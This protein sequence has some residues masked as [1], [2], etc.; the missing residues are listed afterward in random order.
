MILF[1]NGQIFDGDSFVTWMLVNDDGRIE[2]TGN[3]REPKVRNTYDLKNKFVL[4]GF[5]DGH[6]HVY[7][8]GLQKRRLHLNGISSIDSL[9]TALLEFT[10][11]HKNDK[12]IV[13]HGWDQDLFVENRY[14][15]RADLD[16]VEG[17]LP[18]ILFRAC[19]HIAV[20]NTPAINELGLTVSTKIEG[21][22][23]DSINGELTGV[24]RENALQLVKSELEIDSFENRVETLKQGLAEVTKV[25]ITSVQTND[26]NAWFLYKFLVDSN[27]LNIR[28]FLTIPYKEIDMNQ[29]PKPK[30]ETGL[31]RAER[32][33]LFADGSLGASTAAL[34]E[35]YY[36][37][38]GSGS[39][40]RGILIDDFE[41]LRSKVDHIRKSGWDIE[42]HA[43][44]DLACQNVLKIYQEVYGSSSRP[45]V[46]HVQVIN[47][48]I[49]ELFLQTNAIANIQPAFLPTDRV[50][51]EQRLGD[52][53]KL[54]YA[55]RTLIES[56]IHVSGGSDAPIELPDPLSGIYAA[57]FRKS[58]EQDSSWNSEE[59]ISIENAVKLF[60][61]SPSFNVHEE[62]RI[63]K[64]KTGYFADFNIFSKN[65]LADPSLIPTT[66]I[67][68][69]YVNGKVIY[70]PSKSN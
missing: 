9:K 8:I 56:G 23:L 18:V 61:H 24:I 52:R 36:D 17:T 37:G 70:H 21:G 4:P 35:P 63:G 53:A 39:D 2:S 49:I 44:G 41:T 66:Q 15:T 69:V 16:E 55:W 45:I 43:I 5:H 62:N 50:W 20:I 30:E 59:A 42:T 65:F 29:S 58:Y 34:I 12:W 68:S 10:K 6:I 26:S 14:P 13:G 54:S 31:L 48:N 3:D 38:S 22:E 11:H 27:Q 33:K 60:T 67:E 40:G 57:V 19:N 46:T 32:V 7:N 1:R 51:A 47:P 64:L 25:G 28:V